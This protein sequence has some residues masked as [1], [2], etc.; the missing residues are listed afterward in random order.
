MGITIDPKLVVQLEKDISSPELGYPVMQQLLAQHLR[1]TA[2][3]AFNDM[4]ANR[5]HSRPARLRPARAGR[6]FR[7]RAR[8]HSRRRLQQST[9][10]HDPTT[11]NPTG[12]DGGTMRA[13][14]AARLRTVS[15][16]DYV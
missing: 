12:K 8:R 16:T 9:S 14:P 1:F 7:H 13:Q 2:V 10:D 11:L 4:S 3:V 5:R 6:C 15:G